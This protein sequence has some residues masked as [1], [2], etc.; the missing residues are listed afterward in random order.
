MY[1]TSILNVQN[2]LCKLAECYVSCYPNAGLP[3][4]MGGYDET[5]EMTARY[6]LYEN[7]Q[8]YSCCHKI[9][10]SMLIE[11]FAS[12]LKDFAD[13]GL[14]NLA[15][16]CC[17]TTPETIAAISKALKGATARKPPPKSTLLRLS[18]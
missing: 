12:Y 5:A 1:V 14:L 10:V 13:A 17:G 2:Q 11:L 8:V 6:Q 15:G 4:A 9:Y 3:N 16:G 7:A 18:G